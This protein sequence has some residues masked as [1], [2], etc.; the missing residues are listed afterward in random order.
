MTTRAHSVNK[1]NARWALPKVAQMSI[2]V[3]TWTRL[4]AR[5][6]TN[7]KNSAARDRWVRNSP[8]ASAADSVISHVC[9]LRAL[10]SVAQQFTSVLP[11]RKRTPADTHADVLIC[12]FVER[13]AAANV[14]LVTLACKLARADFVAK[15]AVG[16]YCLAAWYSLHG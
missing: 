2:I 8:A 16:F 12:R 6:G 15:Y 9:A 10:P 13:W 11:T 3:S 4:H 14:A 7:R 1:C 5:I